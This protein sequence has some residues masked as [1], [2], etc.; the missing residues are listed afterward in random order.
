MTDTGTVSITITPVND[1]D[2][3]A[4]NESFTVAEGG[5]ATE[6][7][8]DA[9]ATLLVGDTD[10]DLPND[11]LT[12]SLD[13]GPAFA[14][15]FTL[16]ADGT[17]S[18]THDGSENFTDSFTYTLTDADGGVTDTGTVSITITP[19]NDNDPIADNESFTVA[20]GGTATEVDLDVGATLLTGDT[21][22]DLPN[23]NLSISLD[24]GPLFASAFTLNAD[25]T[26]SYTHDG[27]E[28]F[29]DSF[30]Y[31]LTDA[32]GGLTD[33]G[34]VSITITPVNDHDPVA[35][36]ESFTVTE[37]GTATQADLDVGATLLSG[38][39]DIDLPNDT[40]TISLD[41]GPAFASAFT[42][43]T[44][45][46]FSYTHDG[47]ENFTDSF[48][49]TLTDADGGLADTGTV[50]ITITPVNDNDPIADDESFTVAEG[51]TA[52]EADLDA[53][54][55][56]LVGDTDVDLP[57]DSLAIS[58][59]TGPT[60]ASAFTL[61]ADGTF[62]YTHDGSENFTDSF[63]YTLADAD[64]G[65][66]DTGTVNITITPVNDNDPIADNE[67]F[68]VVEGGTATEA[69]LDA[70]ATLLVG[71]TDID[72]PND[73]LTISL[74][75]G[76]AYASAFSLN[77][78]GTFSYTHNGSENFTDSF[79]YTLTDANGGVADTGTV[80]ITVTPL[81]DNDPIAND[82]SLTLNEGATATVLDSTATSV[83]ANDTDADLPNDTLT[84]TVGTGPSFA[85]AFTLNTDG[86]FSYTHDGSE[87]FTDSFTY[88][89]SDA[90]GGVMD[91]GTVNIVINPVNDNNP[92]ANNDSITLNEGA[93]ATVL[94][95]TAT[96][97][98]A[99]DSD[100]DLPNDALTVTLGSGP[101]FASAF[102]FNPDGTFSYS[103]DGSENLTDSFSYIVSD[104]NG[105][106]TD[107]G[108]VNITVNPVND[109]DPVA[110][111]DAIT[112]TVGSS[113]SVLNTG[114]SSVL[115]N[116]GDLDLPN[117]SLSASLLSGPSAASS[118]TLNPDGTFSYTHNGGPATSDSFTYIVTDA[119]GGITDTATVSINITSSNSPPVITSNGGGDT[120]SV[121]VAS[122]QTYVTTVAAIDADGDSVSYS[123]VGGDSANFAINA[124]T[125]EISLLDSNTTATYVIDVAANDGVGGSDVQT[126]TVAVA[127]VAEVP[128]IIPPPTPGPSESDPQNEP[129]D[130]LDFDEPTANPTASPTAGVSGEQ[131]AEAD[132]S[133]ANFDVTTI[134]VHNVAL[135]DFTNNFGGRYA[136]YGEGYGDSQE[137]EKSSNAN[138]DNV[139]DRNSMLNAL[140]LEID[141]VTADMI[142]RVNQASYLEVNAR[143]SVEMVGLVAIAGL[144][145][146][147][148][149]ASGLVG[150][151]MSSLPLWRWVD[152]MP[153]LSA[154]AESRRRF[155]AAK[156]EGDRYEKHLDDMATDDPE[157]EKRA[158]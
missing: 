94:D 13:T 127:G 56:L 128:I 22:A 8:L 40:L 156:A 88:V 68:T 86:T 75:T 32:D 154:D 114:V 151:A 123:I 115:V 131:A 99:N 141:V 113:A 36:D 79:T 144:M 109:N 71:D 96:S 139:W 110:V 145:N 135:T 53:G 140:A 19:V 93:S 35:D 70:G 20:E 76:P 9:G 119:D 7:N 98:L 25:G 92:V 34:T 42:L 31:T 46:T 26:F 23:D 59:G 29:T 1:N 137:N 155:E 116:D 90:N 38:D 74:D 153:I 41:T 15:A 60:F 136:D 18:Y 142:E 28:N 85:G 62:S 47:S 89:V 104:A 133:K 111:D 57:N 138:E 73:T 37:G 66:T 126:I 67:S 129:T 24:T 17:F 12:V 81:N 11:T 72:L 4:D 120:G 147:V 148:L 143:H 118:F 49:Y 52:T 50:N 124:T 45:G 84:V 103:H 82:D 69:D 108:T 152:P 121:S 10:V 150:A 55:T 54:A 2:P 158:R 112:L 122:S 21:D 100:N 6:A 61:N 16:N 65:V 39:S 43:N 87:N 51:G 5:T 30:T 27:S 149:K 134:K 146:V 130:P 101:S 58:L 107:T 44:N 48:T 77:T 63:T 106:V 3:V 97:V 132:G 117:D 125:G 105:G 95:S 157:T 33:T 80:T 83:L 102:T 64:G 91:S 78:D 14:S